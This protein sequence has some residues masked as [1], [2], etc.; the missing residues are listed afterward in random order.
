MSQCIDFIAQC[1][2]GHKATCPA[3]MRDLRLLSGGAGGAFSWIRSVFSWAVFMLSNSF[4][5][6]MMVA[7]IRWWLFIR[8]GSA[9][10]CVRIG[11]DLVVHL[12]LFITMD[13]GFTLG[14]ILLPLILS[15]GLR[16]LGIFEESGLV[17]FP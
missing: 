12:I 15:V 2:D 7:L 6:L 16:V 17:I 9:L 8:R 10:R 5:R 4:V 14:P 13:L 3:C 11:G 1:T